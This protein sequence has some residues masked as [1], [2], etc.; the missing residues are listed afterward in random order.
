[1]KKE[2]LSLKKLFLFNKFL[3]SYCI[4]TVSGLD[5][6]CSKLEGLFRFIH[7]SLCVHR[8]AFLLKNEHVY[9]CLLEQTFTLE[10]QYFTTPVQRDYIHNMFQ[11]HAQ[12]LMHH[13]T[14]ICAHFGFFAK[15]AFEYK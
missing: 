14:S 1:M 6:T 3:P 5:P 4:I 15:C 12:H 9:V 8:T 11:S 7:I 13:L 10:A 2:I